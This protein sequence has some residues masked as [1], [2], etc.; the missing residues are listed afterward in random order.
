MTEKVAVENNGFSLSPNARLVLEKRYLKKDV[1]GR[2]VESPEDMF[3]RIAKNIASV[4]LLYNK[5]ADIVSREEQF[6][7]L[8]TSLRFLPNSP[9]LMNAGRDLQQLFGCFVLPIEDSVES[10]FEAVKQAALIHKS[11]GGTG[12]SFSRIRPKNDLVSASGGY[13]SGPVSFMKVFNEATEAINQGGFR[14]G[15]NMAVLRIDHPDILNFITAKR[16]EGI[17]T[18]FNIS[19]GITDAFMHAVE[20]NEDFPLINP[21]TK[22]VVKTVN[23]RNLFEQIVHSAW[24]NGEPG[25]LFLDTINAANPTP[26]LGEIEGTN[27]CGEQP[28]LPFEACVLGSIN[29]SRMTKRK[30][31][32]YEIDWDCLEKTTRLAVH[33][34]DNIIDINKYPL[35]QI[36]RLTKGNRK[37]GLGIMGLAD[38]F[39]KLGISYNSEKAIQCTDKIM[40]FF[41]QKAN[42]ASAKLAEE[43]GVFP[44][45]QK[46]I[47]AAPNSHRF[48]NASRTTIAPTGTISIIAHCS[49][50]IEPIF[51][52]AYTRHVLVEGG[53]PEIHPFFEYLA[54]K[55]GFYSEKLIEEVFRNG[56]LQNIHGVPEDVKKIFI[57]AHDVSPKQQIKIQAICQKHIDSGVSKTINFS[58]GSNVDDVRNVFLFAY[59]SRC[60]GITVYRD[61]SRVSQV[62]S[63]ECTCAKQLIS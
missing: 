15:A 21:R 25:I 27:P 61:K 17:L 48:R 62:L 26:V 16:V 10:I 45:Y 54:K 55:R 20:K 56:S 12:F 40:R 52:V 14:R 49:S 3:R 24:E 13:A 4:D 59:K 35:P 38:L 6:Y 30:G 5:R 22:I 19:V 33:F 31:E 50:G 32:T 11:G 39:I 1:A 58:K 42:D 28:L 2:P 36:E 23:A 41:S 60:K 9:T 18:N 8:L 51:S 7:T 47:Y 34:L 63:I 44:N 37:I 46:S 29:L 53:L 57:T 43:R